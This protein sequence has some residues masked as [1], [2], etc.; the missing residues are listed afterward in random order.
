M[1]LNKLA[2]KWIAL[3]G[4]DAAGKSTQVRLVQEWLKA[5]G[6]KALA[7]PEFSGSPLGKTIQSV[8]QTQRFFA[9]HAT[10]STPYADTYALLA[11][12]VYNIEADG[13]AVLENGDVLLSDRGLLSLIGYQAKRVATHSEIQNTD[14]IAQIFSIVRNAMSHIRIPDVHILLKTKETEM[15]RR[16]TARGEEPLS[17]ADLVF[18]REVQTTMESLGNHIPFITLDTSDMTKED[19]TEKIIGLAVNACSKDLLEN[20]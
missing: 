18:M 11:D 10:R 19:V 17:V 3:D 12:L 20:G 5:A 4:T 9:L 2:G 13:N 1:N 6:M 7:L 8:I 16:I 14:S 15:Q